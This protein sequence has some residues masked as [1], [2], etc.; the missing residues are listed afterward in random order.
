MTDTSDPLI[1]YR[2]TVTDNSRSTVACGRSWTP[3]VACGSLNHTPALLPRRLV[4]PQLPSGGGS[5]TKAGHTSTSRFTFHVSR[6]HSSLDTRHPTLGAVRP[7]RPSQTWSNL[8]KPKIFI[9][10]FSPSKLRVQ[11]SIFKA[12]STFLTP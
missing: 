5:Q 4:T 9:L 3:I 6:S 2:L 8:V 12:L 7:V 11:R 10:R 1:D